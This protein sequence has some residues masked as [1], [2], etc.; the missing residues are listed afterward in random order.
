MRAKARTSPQTSTSASATTNTLMFNQK[1]FHRKG[2]N[3]SMA[4]QLRYWSRTAPS[5]ADRKKAKKAT[6][7]AVTLSPATYH[8]Q[9][10]AAALDARAATRSSG[11][12]GA[13]WND[14]DQEKERG[15]GRVT[16]MGQE[17]VT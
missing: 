8:C 11:M 2:R 15:G 6:T 9:S 3:S 10:L 16:V 7:R 13:A 4:S 14:G 1:P 5:L 12:S 17:G